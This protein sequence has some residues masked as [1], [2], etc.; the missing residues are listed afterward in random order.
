MISML[1]GVYCRYLG[2]GWSAA[3]FLLLFG[4]PTCSGFDSPEQLTR[5]EKSG[6]AGEETTRRFQA[7][8]AAYQAERYG[9][10]QRELIRLLAA[11]PNSFEINELTGL[12]YVALGQDE[13]IGRAHV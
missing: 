10:A 8:V 13:K 1:P 12:V 2:S 9:E 6:Q 5:S 11:N 7:A 4:C 3:A